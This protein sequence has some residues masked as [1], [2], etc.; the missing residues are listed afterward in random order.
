MLANHRALRP[1]ARRAD[2]VRD[3]RSGN[4]PALPAG[5]RGAVR[6]ID[7]VG[8]F[9]PKP[10]L[11]GELGPGEMGFITA[12]IKDISE[13]QVGDTITDEKKPC[14]AKLPGFKPSVPM[15][16]CSLFPV[17]ASD[18]EHRTQDKLEPQH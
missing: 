9:A 6:E 10:V 2:A 15:V 8:V 1:V 5:L 3:V 16:F 13:T 12:S 4:I 17:D 18:F 7:R 14:A 11:I